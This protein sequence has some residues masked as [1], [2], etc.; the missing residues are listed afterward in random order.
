[1][2]CCE[3]TLRHVQPPHQQFTSQHFSLVCFHFSF[4][5]LWQYEALMDRM[6]K[7]KFYTT[8]A[9]NYFINKFKIL[10]TEK[11]VWLVEYDAWTFVLKHHVLI[12]AHL[13]LTSVIVETISLRQCAWVKYELYKHKF[14]KVMKGTGHSHTFV[15]NYILVRPSGWCLRQGINATLPRVNKEPV[16]RS[17][18]NSASIITTLFCFFLGLCSSFVFFSCK[19][20]LSGFFS[21]VLMTD[22]FLL[23]S[24]AILFNSFSFVID[25][26]EIIYVGK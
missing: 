14:G 15:N 8:V 23:S 9:K 18:V 20:L 10:C 11:D 13:C 22:I 1:M 24:G 25:N 4:L 12:H 26:K 17:C 16:L 2:P 5:Q 21:Q 3:H 19:H 7:L 6:K